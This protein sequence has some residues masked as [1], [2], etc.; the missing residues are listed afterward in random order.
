MNHDTIIPHFMHFLKLICGSLKTVEIS[1]MVD[2]RVMREG[3]CGAAVFTRN[4]DSQHEPA[5]SGLSPFKQSH[6][7]KTA[8]TASANHAVTYL[9]FIHLMHQS[10]NPHGQ[11]G[12]Q[13][14]SE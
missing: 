3:I 1:R 2:D 7:G 11:C 5:W 9:A 4:S 8:G 10:G 14:M 13:G 12:T 6:C